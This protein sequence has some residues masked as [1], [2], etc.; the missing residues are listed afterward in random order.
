MRIHPLDGIK[1]QNLNAFTLDVEFKV[2]VAT[3]FPSILSYVTK[4][5]DGEY[6]SNT[7]VVLQVSTLERKTRFW[8]Q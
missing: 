4:E 7:A 5:I 8:V 2:D 1:D 6:F 3:A